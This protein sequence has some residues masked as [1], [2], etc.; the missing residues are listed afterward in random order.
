MCGIVGIFNFDNE[1]INSNELKSFTNSLIHRGPDSQGNY[2]NE[3]QNIGLGH[4]RLNIIDL[5]ERA[6]Q[7]MKFKDRF[8]I[9]YNGEIFNYKELRQE[10]EKK[11]YKFQTTSD[12]EVALISFV[13]WGENCQKKFNGM[14]ALTIWDEKTKCL[15]ISRDRFGEKPLY[16]LKNNNK[17]YFASE[18]KAFMFLK[19]ENIPDFDYNNLAYSASTSIH[20]DSVY[21]D[22]TFLKNVKELKPGHQIIVN[23]T[24]QIRLKKWWSTIDNLQNVSIKYEDQIN[25]YKDL[26]LDSCKIRLASDVKI[27]TS[28]SGGIDSSSVLSV[29][30]DKLTK[31]AQNKLSHAFTLNYLNDFDDDIFGNDLK[32][33]NSLNHN[34]INKKIINLDLEKID[35]EDIIKIIYYQEEV[36]GTDGVGPWLIYKKMRENNVKVSIDGHGAD[37]ALG[38][39]SKYLIYAL[40]DVKNDFDL[41]RYLELYFIKLG[42]YQTLNFKNL[43]KIFLNIFFRNKLNRKNS[44]FNIE[45]RPP[46]NYPKDE[47]TKLN[48]LNF[49]LYND[50]NYTIVPYN[51]KKYDKYSMAQ[52]VECRNP[53][54]DWRLVSYTFSLP[55]KSKMGK[56]FTKRILRDS[57]KNFV[58]PKIINRK[59][60]GFNPTSKHSMLKMHN[61]INDTVNSQT[62]RE[63]SIWNSNKIKLDFEKDLFTYQDIFKILQV[64]YI[65]QTFNEKKN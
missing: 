33:S 53:F 32:Y 63:N 61:F 30:N 1:K 47:I 41:I 10:L 44:Y 45:K 38:G 25:E 22:E 58:S 50:F 46:L 57:M 62:F 36:S 20:K 55:P 56:G 48:N 52:S 4:N 18:L 31:N 13:E 43:N 39:Y 17:F 59:K 42:L 26:F 54:L 5:S 40:Q 64:H 7:P 12:T 27:G 34:Q 28:Y 9:N 8:V 16:Y 35:P 15:F 49:N 65:T 19:K 2:I 21:T 60:K 29:I 51:L 23:F 3:A 24:G 14:W 6:N 37:E 11:G